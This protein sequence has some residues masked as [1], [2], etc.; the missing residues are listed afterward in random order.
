MK[1]ALLGTGLLGSAIAQRLHQQ[2][3][4]L[5]VWNRSP[6][7]AEPLKQQGIFVADSASE[8]ITNTKT[9]LLLLSD[10]AAI[11]QVMFRDPAIGSLQGKTL[12][13]MGTIAPDESRYLAGLTQQQGGQYLEA[14]V[15]GSLPE[16]R[17]GTLIVMG[18]GDPGLFSTCLPL[19]R[20][21]GSNPQ[22]IGPVGHAAALKLAM[23][24]LIASLTT[25]FSLSLGLVQAEGVDV[26]QFMSLLR[27]SALYAPT[28][29]KKLEKYLTHS[30]DKPNFP[31]KH[32]VKDTELFA[33]AAARQHM[34]CHP[35][36][37]MLAV[38]RAG[39]AAGLADQD[40]SALY[41][42]VNPDSARP[43][44]AL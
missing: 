25:G 9:C 28:F 20:D 29:D 32:L 8:A 15:L 36:E 3:R 37:A 38:F 13:Q 2:G 5:L 11:E 42:A 44:S 16:A 14:P 21:L 33:M 39:M 18:G 26:N 35:L 30:Y 40:Y 31:L 41:E 10:A 22:R 24:Q 7:R 43:V 27:T 34:D 1:T 23:N 12:I 6:E 19:L 4:P 17:A